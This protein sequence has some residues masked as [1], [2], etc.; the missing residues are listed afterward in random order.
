M[1]AGVI[2]HDIAK[3]EEI[4]SCELGIA[5][6]YTSEGN[7]LGHLV[8][9]ALI[10]DK[11]CDYLEISDEIRTTV[12]HMLIS[13]HRKPEYGAAKA[14]M[15]LEAQV[16]NLMI[17]LQKFM[18]LNRQ[19]KILTRAHSAQRYSLSATYRFTSLT[20]KSHFIPCILCRGFFLQIFKYSRKSFLT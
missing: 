8:V 4:D 5:E 1:L 17:C 15:I 6:K 18:S 12:Q 20:S 9:G 10:V 19:P 13:H 11:A 7:L 14:P 3:I 2:L 16:L